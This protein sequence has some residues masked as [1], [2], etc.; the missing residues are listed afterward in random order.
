MQKTHLQVTGPEDAFGMQNAHLKV[1]VQGWG[2]GAGK[3][4]MLRKEGGAR[5]SRKSQKPLGTRGRSIQNDSSRLA[6]GARPEE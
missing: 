3:R 4:K 1:D 2:C 6:Y 5:R